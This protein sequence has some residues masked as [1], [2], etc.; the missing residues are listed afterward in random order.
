MKAKENFEINATLCIANNHVYAIQ[1]EGDKAR[2]MLC[3]KGDAVRIGN[4]QRIKAEEA[5]PYITDR[6]RRLYIDEARAY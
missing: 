2:Y 6:N 1:L 3:V 4:W 5:R